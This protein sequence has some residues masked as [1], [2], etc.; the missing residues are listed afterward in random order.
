MK[1]VKFI[2]HIVSK[3]SI[4]VDPSNIEAITTWLQ[5]KNVFKI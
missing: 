2:D 5:S 1:E 4:L 3:E